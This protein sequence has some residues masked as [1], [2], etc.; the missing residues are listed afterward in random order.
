[1]VHLWDYDEKVLR[2]SK[3]GRIFLLERLINYGI[4]RSDKEKIDLSEVKANWDQLQLDPARRRLFEF[5]IW[6]K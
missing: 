3:R 6:G 5:L 4:Y 1:M 2:K